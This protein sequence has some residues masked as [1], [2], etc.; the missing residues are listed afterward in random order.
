MTTPGS[1]AWPRHRRKVVQGWL[2]T[3]R[4]PPGW[5][6]DAEA[7]ISRSRSRLIFA[8]DAATWASRLRPSASSSCP[9]GRPRGRVVAQ[10]APGGPASH[11]A[12]PRA[13]RS[14]VACWMAGRS[15]AGGRCVVG[16]QPD[17]VEPVLSRLPR[18][19]AQLALQVQVF[20]QVAPQA[21][22]ATPD[23]Q[24]LALERAPA[25]PGRAVQRHLGAQR[26]Q[27]RCGSISSP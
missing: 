18:P 2:S 26:R 24:P 7:R 19:F 12:N 25:G 23:Q 21:P 20:S 6:H 16:H 3:V 1:R 5:S 8:A 10:A 13:T 11:W 14:T 15:S 27:R 17:P 4:P 9:A 22:P